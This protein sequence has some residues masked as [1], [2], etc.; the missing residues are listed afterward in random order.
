MGLLAGCTTPA[1]EQPAL[2]SAGSS[3]AGAPP[4]ARPTSASAAAASA[5]PPAAASRPSAVPDPAATESALPQSPTGSAYFG[6]GAPI[7]VERLWDETTESQVLEAISVAKA[8]AAEKGRR[9]LLEFVAP[10]CKD[11]HE[12]ARLDETSVVTEQLRSRF[13][14]VRINVGKWD[15][16]EGL[17]T[18][19]E[20]R[21]LA[22][23]IVIDPKTSRL[24]AKTTLEPITKPG[25]KL[26]AKDWAAW[27]ASH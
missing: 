27:L 14:R 25:K 15:R 8:C 26:T 3:P 9:L 19:Y 4:S 2:Q 12:M 10:W 11:C 5:A 13:E 23:Y 18:S 1:R 6:C 22:T 24:L 17:R 20:V 7:P 21:A 16:H